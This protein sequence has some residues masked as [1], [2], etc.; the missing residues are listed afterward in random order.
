MAASF[1]VEVKRDGPDWT[2]YVDGIPTVARESFAVVDRIADELRT[3]GCHYPS[4]AWE[5]A[6]S[7]DRW[8]A[9]CPDC[10]GSRSPLNVVGCRACCRDCGFPCNTDKDAEGFHVEEE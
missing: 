7:I 10:G 3:P 9:A 2:L 8:R 4:E 6:R 1:P 5:V